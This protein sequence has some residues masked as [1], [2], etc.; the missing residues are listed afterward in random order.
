MEIGEEPLVNDE[1]AQGQVRHTMAMDLSVDTESPM[2]RA[3][4][5]DSSP[6]I[7]PK[8][9]VQPPSVNKGS[10][11]Q[12]VDGANVISNHHKAS[13]DVE[14]PVL[15]VDST[16][17]MNDVPNE[18][19]RPRSKIDLASSRRL[20]FGAL[21]L[22]TPKTKEDEKALQAKLMKDVRRSSQGDAIGHAPEKLTSAPA[23]NDDESWRDKIDLRAVE[24]CHDGIKLS[25][26]HSPLS[27]GGTRSRSVDTA[28]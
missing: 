22:K 21:G 3:D 1:E 8:E 27:S 24:C 19:L 6:L 2:P 9:P 16:S 25:T 10:S 7:V 11:S 4:L 15:A 26:P 14:S 23:A 28:T 17:A 20:L 12:A 18:P 5:K 13:E